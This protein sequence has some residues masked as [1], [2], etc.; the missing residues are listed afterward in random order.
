MDAQVVFLILTFAISVLGMIAFVVALIQKQVLVPP[1]AAN[2]IFSN[3]EEG[4][5]ESDERSSQSEIWR[6]LDQSARTPIL[7]F[8]VSSVIWLVV[9]SIFGLLVSFKFNM[10]D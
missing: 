4:H 5:P 6:S 3:G 9:G 10:P 7:F 8:L 1:E 2:S